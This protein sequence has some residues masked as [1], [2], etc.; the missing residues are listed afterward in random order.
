MGTT[1]I[2]IVIPAYNEAGRIGKVVSRVKSVLP[3]ATV[4][5]VDDSSSDVTGQEALE[6][7]AIVV[8]HPINLGYGAALHTGFIFALR[9]NFDVSSPNGWRRATLGL[10]LTGCSNRYCLTMPT[11][12]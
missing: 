12:S 7:G 9:N 2:L 5:V 4:L 8:R 3:G 6:M 1:R 10:W 11:W